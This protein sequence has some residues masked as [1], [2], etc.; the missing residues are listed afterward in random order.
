MTLIG[1][2]GLG[3]RGARA[4][5]QCFNARLSTASR[6]ALRRLTPEALVGDRGAVASVG[7]A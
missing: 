3:I 6:A 4:A 5:Q 1:S 2:A 7:L